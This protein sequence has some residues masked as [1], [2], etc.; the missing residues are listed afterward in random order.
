MAKPPRHPSD[1]IDALE[2]LADQHAELDELFEQIGSATSDKRRL[3]AELADK[4]AAHATIEE[5]LFYPAVMSKQTEQLLRD[6][7]DDHLEIKRML[8]ELL[9]LEPDDAEFDEVMAELEQ[10]VGFHAHDHEEGRLFPIA[11]ALL[12]DDQRA[13]LGNELLAMFDALMAEAPREHVPDET[14]A[15]APLPAP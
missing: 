2:L 9:E 5:K 4:L 7:V 3:F 11:R 10:A 6:A 12:D 1:V 8:A 15:P 13:G 14:D